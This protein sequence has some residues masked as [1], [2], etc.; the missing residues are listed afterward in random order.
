MLL[1]NPPGDSNAQ[2]RLRAALHEIGSKSWRYPLLAQDFPSSSLSYSPFYL[3]LELD[4]VINLFI[5][6]YDGFQ[7]DR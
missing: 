1:H 5:Q 3:V 2:V 6:I 7:L 4:E